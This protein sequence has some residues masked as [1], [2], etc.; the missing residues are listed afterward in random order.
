[1]SAPDFDRIAFF[2]LD[3]PGVSTI[4]VHES[5]TTAGH[6][7]LKVGSPANPEHAKP[8][9]RFFA[10]AAESDDPPV[11][12]VPLYEFVD[13]TADRRAYSTDPAPP[14]AGFQR[15]EKPLCRV[16]P[17]PWRKRK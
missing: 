11:A 3:Q 9:F 8:P 5:K 15:S 2:A 13:H 12:T 10:L 1:M 17:N 7:I 14:L 6:P 16:W 4:A